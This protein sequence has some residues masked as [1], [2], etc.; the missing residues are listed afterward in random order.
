VVAPA[1]PVAPGEPPE[2]SIPAPAAVGWSQ[3]LIRSMMRLNAPMGGSIGGR[4]PGSQPS[5]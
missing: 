4:Q 2:V 3:R 5:L 1:E